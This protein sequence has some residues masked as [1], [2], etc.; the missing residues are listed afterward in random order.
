MFFAK[1]WRLSV[2][3]MLWFHAKP[4]RLKCKDLK[5][6]LTAVLLGIWATPI[7]GL[8]SNK[9]INKMKNLVIILSVFLFSS[10][11]VFKPA[12]KEVVKIQTNAECGMCKERIEGELNYVKGIV[13]AELHVESKVLTVKYKPNKISLEE[14]REKVSEIGYNADDVKAKKDA[15]KALPACCQPG[16]M[17]KEGE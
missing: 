7:L 8:T 16:G 3:I 13:F 9:K 5:V 14:I 4:Q 6:L 10:C 15:Q 2:E 1:T 11:A 17:E 12:E